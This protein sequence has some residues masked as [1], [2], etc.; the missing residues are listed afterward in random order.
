MSNITLVAKVNNWLKDYEQGTIILDNLSTETLEAFLE[1]VFLISSDYEDYYDAKDGVNSHRLVE[2]FEYASTKKSQLGRYLLAEAY[3]YGYFGLEEDESKAFDMYKELAKEGY[4]IAIDEL[5]NKFDVDTRDRP[6]RLTL[7]ETVHYTKERIKQGRTNLYVRLSFI[8]KKYQKEL[9][10]EDKD[11]FECCKLAVEHNDWTYEV[12]YTLAEYY[13][14]G[15]GTAK[16]MTKAV[17]LYCKVAEDCYGYDKY[18][19][20]VVDFYYK[21]LLDG[22]VSD[23]QLSKIILKLDLNENTAYIYREIGKFGNQTIAYRLGHYYSKKD[24]GLAFEW[25]LKAAEKGN[26][27]A[28]CNVGNCYERGYGVRQNY[29]KA[30]KWYLLSAEKNDH[31]ACYSL[32]YFYEY[33]LSG[34]VDYDKAFEYYN[35]A[36]DMVTNN[37]DKEHNGS[38]AYDLARMY[39]EGKGVEKDMEKAFELLEFSAL[40]DCRDL[41]ERKE[42]DEK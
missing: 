39:R 32:G 38:I 23:K 3:Y 9:H 1:D 2:V 6:K 18:I 14:Q 17:Q 37:Y 27:N 24:K 4:D 11:I 29:A 25:W 20:K 40:N 33:G 42:L 10:L 15:K 36:W 41:I 31:C 28:M 22:V 34:V 30:E 7:E 26:A 8:Y 5:L 19:L 16:D 12:A 35:K 13:E 21:G